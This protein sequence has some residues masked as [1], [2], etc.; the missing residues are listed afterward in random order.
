MIAWIFI[1]IAA[2]FV[3]FYLIGLKKQKKENEDYDDIYQNHKYKIIDLTKKDKNTKIFIKDIKIF[4]C[5]NELKVDRKVESYLGPMGDC[6]SDE[7]Y[8]NFSYYSNCNAIALILENSNYKEVEILIIDDE[9]KEKLFKAHYLGYHGG[10]LYGDMYNIGLIRDIPE[11]LFGSSHDGIIS[12][13]DI[14][15]V[16]K[17]YSRNIL[18]KN[19]EQHLKDEAKKQEEQRLLN[20]KNLMEMIEKN[21]KEKEKRNQEFLIKEKYKNIFN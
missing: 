15:Q 18:K 16:S 1:I 13:S 10:K 8:F 5:I 3:G 14:L 12:F 11:D 7:T 4:Q 17:K 19:E 6:I 9:E 21:I 2:I 20:E